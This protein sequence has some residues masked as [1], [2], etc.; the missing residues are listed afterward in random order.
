[1][2]D[3]AHL[4][5]P[6]WGELLK[7]GGMVLGSPEECAALMQ[8]GQH[9]LVFPGGGR[10]V[11]RRKNE[12]YQ[13]IWKQRVGFAR[14]AI[15]HGYDIIPFASVGANETYKILWDADDIMRTPVWR[16]ISAMVDLD[17]LVR[18]GDML[19]PISR[20]IG[21]SWIPKPQRYYFGFGRRIST[22]RWQGKA[23]DE[24]AWSVRHQVEKSITSQVDRLL[25]QRK[26]EQHL[27][28]GPVRRLLSDI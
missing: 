11:M 20:G 6:V 1:L 26:S 9:V 25:K 5:I 17:N 16:R 27:K 21:L 28:W 19:P 18:G 7:R 12:A 15:E 4:Q 14:M 2:G 23:T 10:E 22:K 24:S 3:R 8:S 13:L